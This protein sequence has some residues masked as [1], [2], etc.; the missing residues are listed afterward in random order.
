[1][2]YAIGIKPMRTS[3]RST[4]SPES[5]SGLGS[6]VRWLVGVDGGGTGTRARLQDASGR[7]LGQGHA[8][9]SGLS[10]GAEQAWRHIDQAIGAA[11]AAA[12][13]PRPRPAACA[14][15]LALAGAERSVNREAFLAADPGYAL[16]LLENDALGGLRGAFAGGPGR[17]VAVGTGSVAAARWPDGRTRLIGG[18]GFPIGDQG[19]GAWLG[20]RA[21][22]HAQAAMDGRCTAGPLAQALWDRCGSTPP[23]LLD[24]SLQS[25]QKAYAEL[26]PLVFE[27]GD[28]D[29]EAGQLLQAAATEVAALARALQPDDTDPLPL[30]VLGSVGER[31]APRLPEALSRHLVAPRGDTM[32]GALLRLREALQ[33]TSAPGR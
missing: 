27:L 28:L 24:W 17:V 21:M 26:A 7:T 31:L 30:V 14:L 29:P 16:C 1:M 32:D 3:L 12:G 11:F 4:Q 15:A 13:V 20:V 6:G 25:G 23:A 33:P 19:S 5:E 8:G 22:Q 9:P 18:W 2:W 10:Q